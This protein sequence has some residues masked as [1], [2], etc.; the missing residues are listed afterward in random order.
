MLSPSASISWSRVLFRL[1]DLSAAVLE[2]Y[3]LEVGVYDPL[4]VSAEGVH[5]CDTKGELEVF[6]YPT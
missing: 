6:R 2:I 4:E 3:G 1:S 5:A